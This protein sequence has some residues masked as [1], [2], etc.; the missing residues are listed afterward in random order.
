MGDTNE[1]FNNFII[2]I[3]GPSGVGKGTVIKRLLAN[4]QLNLQLSI[5]ATTRPC[6]E[7]EVNGR[8]Y[9]FLT[10]DDFYKGIQNNEFIEWIEYGGSQYGTLKKSIVDLLKSDKNVVF[11][12][13]Y[14]GVQALKSV[15]KDVNIF[16]IFI[17]PPSFEALKERLIERHSENLDKINQRI[18]IAR[19]EINHIDMYNLVV[20]NDDLEQCY[21]K[22][23]VALFQILRKIV[24]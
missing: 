2:A 8:E 13:D 16:S 22:I 14:R 20:T 24:K 12:I 19:E 15:F 23:L 18:Q 9:F 11:E 5:S 1:S 10:K 7:N 6:R 21:Q 3:S 4:D 17:L